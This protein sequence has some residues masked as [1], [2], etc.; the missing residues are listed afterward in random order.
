MANRI[1]YALLMTALAVLGSAVAGA[2]TPGQAT[3]S[4][5]IVRGIVV[6]K[7]GDLEFGDLFAGSGGTLS[8]SPAGARSF[9]G[10][11]VPFTAPFAAA[12][13]NVYDIDGKG[14]RKFSFTIIEP[15]VNLTRLS[16]TET[17]T[18]S[19]FTNDALDCSPKCSK[20]DITIYVGA[21]LTVAANQEPGIYVGMFTVRV[22]QQ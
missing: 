7:A 15:S 8:I 19:G 6:E 21:T 20:T 16:G 9:T 17:M 22:D 5:D 14:G 18:V 3:A 1:R 12:A 2:Q 4:A 11:V 13:F 10:G